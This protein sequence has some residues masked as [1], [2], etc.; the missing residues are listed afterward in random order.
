MRA[1]RG[2]QVATSRKTDDADTVRLE[3]PGHGIGAGE[4]NRPLGI[5]Q[6]N[7][8]SPCWQPIF[9]NH[10]GDTLFVQPPGY[11]VAFGIDRQSSIPTP[12]ANHDSRAVRLFRSINSDFCCSLFRLTLAHR[13]FGRP[14]RH[15]LWNGSRSLRGACRQNNQQTGKGGFQLEFPRKSG[16][17]LG[18]YTACTR[19]VVV[20]SP[21]YTLGSPFP[22]HSFG[23]LH[24]WH[25]VAPP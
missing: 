22:C 4:A 25:G 24:W 19:V 23:Y 16:G 7:L 10:T 8:R 5:Q 6:G 12:R 15:D 17:N 1:R 3:P 20:L 14:E 2:C 9:Q 13:G 11:A 18:D 21:D